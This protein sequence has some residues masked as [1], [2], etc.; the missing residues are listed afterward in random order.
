MRY[1]DEAWLQEKR[2]LLEQYRKENRSV[3]KG[4]ILFAG[5]SLMFHFP[6]EKMCAEIGMT[7]YN[8]GVGGYEIDDYMKVLDTVILDLEPSVI[9][10]N[11]GT[12][13]IGDPDVSLDEM[14]G[15]YEHLLD[16]VENRLP[17]ASV[18]LMA[19]YPVDPHTEEELMQDELKT[20]TNE[21]IRRANQEVER[22]AERRALGFIDVNSPITDGNGC[23]KKEYSLDGVHITE[24][25]YEAIFKELKKHLIHRENT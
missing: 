4:G 16:V 25:G 20:R 13:D 9:Y 3:Q 6:I 19:Y 23:L 7:V 22:M 17:D 24:E 5:S 15:R 2:L 18:T 8:R 21:A 12:N 10:M 14:I 11:I 1:R